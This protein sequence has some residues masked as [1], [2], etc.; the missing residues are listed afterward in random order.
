MMA[1]DAQFIRQLDRLGQGLVEAHG[2]LAAPLLGPWLADKGR[3]A[4][5]R[6]FV[7]PLARDPRP[8]IRA[9]IR[10]AATASPTGA[11]PPRR[12]RP[13]RISIDQSK[14]GGRRREQTSNRKAIADDPD[15]T[16]VSIGMAARS[17]HP[18]QDPS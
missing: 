16:S 17:P 7:R 3:P 4:F 14:E 6:G 18:V 2:L 13:P 8:V 9:V 5:H 10:A 15:Q 1:P 12:R 11:A